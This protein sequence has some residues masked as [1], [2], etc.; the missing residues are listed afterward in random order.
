MTDWTIRNPRDREV[1]IDLLRKSQGEAADSPSMG[2]YRELP[3]SALSSFTKK[4]QGM[5][6]RMIFEGAAAY[7]GMLAAT[8]AV[9]ADFK[10]AAAVVAIASVGLAVD[11]AWTYKKHGEIKQDV[12]NFNAS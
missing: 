9:C 6:S 12:I 3:N 8:V 7:V 10:Q 11:S 2:Y 1:C 4:S 5:Q